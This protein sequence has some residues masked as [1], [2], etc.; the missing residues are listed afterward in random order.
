MKKKLA[1][2]PIM[3]QHNN[4]SCAKGQA[5]VLFLKAKWQLNVAR[6]LE[7]V[8]NSDIEKHLH[9][10]IYLFVWVCAHTWKHIP[11]IHPSPFN[12]SNLSKFTWGFS[13][14]FAKMR[15]HVKHQQIFLRQKQHMHLHMY[16]LKFF[17]FWKSDSRS[18]CVGRIYYPSG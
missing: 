9:S 16:K 12:L 8:C 11:V 13:C 5:H 18:K 10:N 15:M 4:F 6:A 2:S 3:S 14:T 7:Y 1:I 17:L